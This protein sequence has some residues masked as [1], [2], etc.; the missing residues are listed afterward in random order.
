M[1]GSEEKVALVRFPLRPAVPPEA[2]FLGIVSA[3]FIAKKLTVGCTPGLQ[4]PIHDRQ[5]FSAKRAASRSVFYPDDFSHLLSL[6]PVKEPRSSRS[7]SIRIFAKNC[8]RSD[9]FLN[10]PSGP[11]GHPQPSNGRTAK[12]LSVYVSH[13]QEK[14]TYVTS[15]AGIHTRKL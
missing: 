13:S 12:A 2:H 14:I 15:I 5:M 3:E 10:E 11:V 4:F 1:P 8:V 9:T 6:T 7:C